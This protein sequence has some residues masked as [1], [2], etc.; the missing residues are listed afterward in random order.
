MRLPVP[1]DSHIQRS[2]LA[3]EKKAVPQYASHRPIKCQSRSWS[4]EVR[5]STG[6]IM[7]TTRYSNQTTVSWVRTTV[8]CCCRL[9]ERQVMRYLKRN[10]SNRYQNGS[11]N[12]LSPDREQPWLIRIVISFPRPLFSAAKRIH[13]AQIRLD[14]QAHDSQ[15]HTSYRNKENGNIDVYGGASLELVRLAHEPASSLLEPCASLKTPYASCPFA[16]P[17]WPA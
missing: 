7:V 3:T 14:Q 6:L 16:P 13:H 11:S 8:S 15:G 12:L 17:C 9:T 4:Q 10:G 1:P 2:V 5:R